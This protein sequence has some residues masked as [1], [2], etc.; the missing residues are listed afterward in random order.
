MLVVVQQSLVVLVK[1]AVWEIPYCVKWLVAL[2]MM[3]LGVVVLVVVFKG[4]GGDASVVMQGEKDTS[5]IHESNGFH[6][7]ELTE[8]DTEC[9][10][11]SWS[12]WAL[13]G[14]GVILLLKVSHLVHYCFFTKRIVRNRL[15][16]LRTGLNNQ[17]NVPAP[18]G[19]VVDAPVE[20]AHVVV[21]PLLAPV[22]QSH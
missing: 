7:V 1:M 2:V 18:A 6:L 12:E 21:P 19:V 13:M 17:P 14:L 22:V 5:N 15:A 9:G 20:M 10:Q 3:V 16:K 8:G 4:N 11:F